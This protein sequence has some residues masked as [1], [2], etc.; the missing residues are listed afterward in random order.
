V[1]PEIDIWRAAELMRKRYGKHALEESAARLTS[2][3]SRAI[4]TSTDLDLILCSEVLFYLPF[5]C[6]RAP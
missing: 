4:A 5:E 1:I 2:L 3:L 6:G